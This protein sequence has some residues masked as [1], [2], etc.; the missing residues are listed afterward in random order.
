MV[1]AIIEVFPAGDKLVAGKKKIGA[2]FRQAW[3]PFYERNNRLGGP[4][5]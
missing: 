2:K 1:G 4:L 3:Q 5:G